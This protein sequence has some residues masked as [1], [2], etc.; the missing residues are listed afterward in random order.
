MG[1]EKNKAL[2]RKQ[3]AA[4]KRAANK[5][6]KVEWKGFV[7]CDLTADHKA[8][9]EGYDTETEF[10]LREGL[11]EL[12]ADGYKVSFSKDFKNN[13]EMAIMYDQNPQ[14]DFAG[15]ALVGRGSSVW[16]AWCALMYRHIV[17]LS[18]GWNVEPKQTSR[19]G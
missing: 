17:I 1:Y 10:P 15:Y 7:N 19:Y 14:S 16:D 6:V 9:L 5:P 8:D 2:E 4:E 13:C 12:A 11:E 3:K 18:D